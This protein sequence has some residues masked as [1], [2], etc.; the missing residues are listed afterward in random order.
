MHMVYTVI[1]VLH[2]YSRVLHYF[3]F[4]KHT[5]CV[6]LQYLIK[7]KLSGTYTCIISSFWCSACQ[8]DV[9]N[10][11]PEITPRWRFRFSEAVMLQQLPHIYLCRFY[12]FPL[13][14]C[15]LLQKKKKNL[16]MKLCY[17]LVQ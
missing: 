10:D 3:N 11:R 17:F 7:I 13:I 9:K 6:S 4:N 14:E 5:I 1:L 2:I 8:E 15:K 16:E 12:F